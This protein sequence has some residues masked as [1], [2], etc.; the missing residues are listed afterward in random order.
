MESE[1]AHFVNGLLNHKRF[2]RFNKFLDGLLVVSYHFTS[3]QISDNTLRC[4]TDKW[5]ENRRPLL[6][7]VI[8]DNH[9]KKTTKCVEQFQHSVDILRD[10][11]SNVFGTSRLRTL[12]IPSADTGNIALNAKQHI[13]LF[14]WSRVLIYLGYLADFCYESDYLVSLPMLENALMRLRKEAQSTPEFKNFVQ[15]SDSDRYSHLSNDI[16]DIIANDAL[17]EYLSILISLDGT[18]TPDR[19]PLPNEVSLW[20]RVIQARLEK[21]GL[22]DGN[23]GDPYGKDTE[24]SL[25]ML[26]R[27]I[28][29]TDFMSGLMVMPVEPFMITRAENADRLI[30]LL[31]L[32][33]QK[34][35]LVFFDPFHDQSETI[36]SWPRSHFG[37]WLVAKNHMSRRRRYCPSN[38][39]FREDF[40]IHGDRSPEHIFSDGPNRLGLRLIQI[41]MAQLGFYDG[42]IDGHFSEESRNALYNLVYSFGYD[43]QNI[44][45]PL[46]SGYFYIDLRYLAQNIFSAGRADVA[47]NPD[48]LRELRTEAEDAVSRLVRLPTLAATEGGLPNFLVRTGKLMLP[49]RRIVQTAIS[50]LA[51]GLKRI[52]RVIERGLGPLVAVFHTVTEGARKA[53]RLVTLS[54]RPWMHFAI[55]V[56][57]VTYATD[58]SEEISIVT[59]FGVDRDTIVFV[60]AGTTTQE[61]IRHCKDIRVL[62]RDLTTSLRI[63]TRIASVPL[64]FSAGPFAWVQIAF[65]FAA[66]FRRLLADVIP[67]AVEADSR[68]GVV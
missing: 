41:K 57:V 14:K 20:S 31:S 60:H 54:A 46:D 51:C 62:L 65:D 33:D 37:E 66:F 1:S 23:V 28:S 10:G 59:H 4:Q 6:S 27:Y 43:A 68:I 67:T 9:D 34:G 13:D 19:V 12:E 52:P 7:L 24:R 18:M 44:V 40:P 45:V 53:F 47:S 50:A 17:L 56:P 26:A 49:M 30:E 16:G 39:L 61:L 11:I 32:S 21:L 25:I 42:F 36:V 2:L 35:F 29:R 5:R 48:E 3:T 63:A 15:L 55:G 22:F 58:H 64:K 38:T 8:S